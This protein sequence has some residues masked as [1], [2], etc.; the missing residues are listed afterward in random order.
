MYILHTYVHDYSS[1]FVL[2]CFTMRLISCTG[3]LCGVCIYHHNQQSPIHVQ[4]ECICKTCRDRLT[5]IYYS[6]CILSSLHLIRLYIYPSGYI[7]VLACTHFPSLSHKDVYILHTYVHDYSSDFV[8][9]CFN[10][11][12]ISCT[13][14]LYSVCIYHTYSPGLCCDHTRLICTFLGEIWIWWLEDVVLCLVLGCTCP[15]SFYIILVV[16][17]HVLHNL[18]FI[19]PVHSGW[20]SFRLPWTP[21]LMVAMW[22]SPSC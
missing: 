2:K 11:G 22:T 9:K 4:K 19:C 17:A 5:C 13:G 20:I 12:L 14:T 15:S 6:V 8:L 21:P 18:C 3:T 7:G 1:D 10:M 16:C